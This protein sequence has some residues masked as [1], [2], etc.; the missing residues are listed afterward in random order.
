V[1][2]LQYM[3]RRSGG[4][5]SQEMHN[6]ALKSSDLSAFVLPQHAPYHSSAVPI[7]ASMYFYRRTVQACQL[8]TKLA[9]DVP[10][11]AVELCANLMHAVKWT[12]TVD[13]SLFNFNL[14][15][16]TSLN[17]LCTVCMAGRGGIL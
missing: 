17:D 9:G 11:H 7:V 5:N 3:G 13:V 6:N 14:S 8:P 10:W 1:F 12:T 16:C 15:T 4:L 2:Q